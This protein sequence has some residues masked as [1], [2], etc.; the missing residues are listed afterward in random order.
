MTATAPSERGLS[1]V[2]GGAVILA[3]V[4]LFSFG[5]PLYR[6]IDA[7]TDWQ[8]VTLRS[9]ALGTGV[10]IMVAIRHG[11]RIVPAFRAI[12]RP[13][14]VGGLAIG[15]SF[16]CHVL[17][18]NNT[19]VANALFLINTSP[20]FAAVLGW[21]VL[22]ERVRPVVA[23]ASAASVAG[24]LIMV[25][26]GLDSGGHLGNLAGLGAALSFAVFGVA[27]RARP[28]V[29]MAPVLCLGAAL[30]TLFALVAADTAVVGLTDLALC[31][32][33]GAFGAGGFF[34]LTAGAR[35]VPAAEIMLLC[36]AEAILAPVWV[37]LVVDEVPATLTF[38]GG[39]FILGAV[40]AL[41]L[42]AMRGTSA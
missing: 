29:D 5:G 36:L 15:M 11:R 9:A 23:A 30:S 12:G 21:L 25:Y 26:D 22:R 39:A 32:A 38:V 3:G 10:L 13:G 41:A 42:S 37:W 18:L 1:Y 33:L 8:I 34:L 14:L 2:G 16:T 31:L 17:A 6:L 35:S 20:V 27:I 28:N 19:T 40:A 7:A 4:V 24:A